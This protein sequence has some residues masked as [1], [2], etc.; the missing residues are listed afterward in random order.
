MQTLFGM[1]DSRLE[2]QDYAHERQFRAEVKSCNLF[3]SMRLTRSH[4]GEENLTIER[5]L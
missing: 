1:F 3:H 2:T 5:V 4:D